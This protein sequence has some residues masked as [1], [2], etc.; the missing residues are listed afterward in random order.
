L[1]VAIRKRFTFLHQELVMRG[2][3]LDTAPRETLATIIILDQFSRNMFRGT[4]QAFAADPLALHL[5]RAAVDRGLDVG[6][7]KNERLFMYLPFE[8]SEDLADQDRAVSLIAT[9]QDEKLLQ[10]ALAHKSIIMRFTRFPH[11]NDLLGR[12]STA[13]EI[14]FL[15]QSGS[16]F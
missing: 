6:L 11:R 13:E 9:L 3:E 15:K 12:I 14:E 5:A 4:A 7:A 2:W 1:D 8:H 16:T 10:Y